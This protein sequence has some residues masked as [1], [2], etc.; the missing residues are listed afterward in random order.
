MSNP[1]RGERE[2][3]EELDTR[4]RLISEKIRL[5]FQEVLQSPD[6]LPFRDS[7][8]RALLIA[9]DLLADHGNLGKNERSLALDMKEDM[10]KF[11]EPFGLESIE[12]EIL[13]LLRDR[14]K[15]TSG[16]NSAS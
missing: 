6:N 1:E 15:Q 7:V 9:E 11:L 10:D 4:R 12:K 2:S 5:A 8:R 16:K 13:E 14:A 3:A